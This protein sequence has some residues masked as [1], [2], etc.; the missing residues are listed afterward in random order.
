MR[1]LAGVIAPALSEE[2]AAVAA[3]CRLAFGACVLGAM[4]RVAL[5]RQLSTYHALT[6]MD[7]SIR[8]VA[9]V[10]TAAQ[11][12][13]A[14]L[15]PMLW[16]VTTLPPRLIATIAAGVSVFLGGTMLLLLCKLEPLLSVAAVQ[17]G[18]QSGKQAPHTAVLLLGAALALP[19]VV[20]GAL[21]AHAVALVQRHA[22]SRT[23][24]CIAICLLGT[25]CGAELSRHYVLSV[26]AN[27]LLVLAALC[28]P[29]LLLGR[30]LP[31]LA[32][33][34][35]LA[36]AGIEAALE[37]QRVALPELYDPIKPQ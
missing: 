7:M 23:G 2:E 10:I 29:P 20:C 27:S 1:G 24:I 6:A 11:V 26:G 30:P 15:S 21:V 33:A 19:C 35:V 12:L 8:L 36:V 18:I 22:P 31:A 3:G 37:Q 5:T 25:V 9:A 34:P 17:T 14:A 28:A 4:I 16:A 13:G 32:L